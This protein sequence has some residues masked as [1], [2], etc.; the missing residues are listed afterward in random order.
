[1]TICCKPC[2]EEH[3]EFVPATNRGDVWR[4]ESCAEAV[5]ERNQARDVEAFHGA[6]SWMGSAQIERAKQDGAMR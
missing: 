5:W 4:C 1:M 2:Y 3:G 6:S